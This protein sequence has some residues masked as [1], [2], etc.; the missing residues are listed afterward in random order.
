LHVADPKHTWQAALGQ[1]QLA[2]TPGNYDTWLRD[3]WAVG[4]DSDTFIVGVEKP[5]ARDYLEARLAGMIR[6]TLTD[7]RG[8]PTE[9]RFVT[10]RARVTAPPVDGP[11]LQ[12]ADS[13]ASSPGP[14]ASSSAPA[15]VGGPSTEPV[16]SPTTGSGQA[17][18]KGSGQVG[19]SAVP[20]P[21]S[22]Q[23]RLNPRLTFDTFV[24]GNSNRL[25]HAASRAVAD[26]PGHAYNPLFIYGGV[27]L[28]K[29]H[30]LH[31]IGHA[32]LAQGLA[33]VYVSSETFTNELIE[34]IRRE[35]TE[36]FRQ[37]YRGAALLLIDDIQF[38]A[39][40]EAT[41][42]EFF[43]TFNAIHEAGG[44]IVLSSDRPPK[45][46]T[47]LEERLQSRF[48]MGLIA[49][50]QPPDFETRVAILRSKQPAHAA[51]SVPDEV[52]E[53]IAHRV[54]SNIRELEG[55]LTRVLAYAMEYQRPITVDVAA[56]ALK[57]VMLDVARPTNRP[58]TI[59]A[60]VARYY[61]VTADALRGKARDKKI[62]GPRQVA[63]YLLREDAKLSLPDIGAQLGGR[64]HTTVLHGVR[65][66]QQE[67]DRD[68]PVRNDLKG[69]RDAMRE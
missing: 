3:T 5:I 56:A 1:L 20:I 41:Q 24:V 29:T 32:V 46:I 55:S 44:Q 67:L 40:R 57:E 16:L 7:L 63:M 52:L 27:G 13:R 19:R 22:P 23:A 14:S 54:Q 36:E 15:A 43:H 9:V 35:R 64:D 47:I 31:A 53:F 50:V 65:A 37:K 38:I 10:Q 59:L 69:V 4:E 25:A 68:G 48:A 18:S 30:L 6:K 34:S 17:L 33:V 26:N 51:V 58:D 28:G 66:V 61:G 2:V 11:L 42:Q 49:D 60:A 12:P 39:G 62:V 45:A 21:P 8:R